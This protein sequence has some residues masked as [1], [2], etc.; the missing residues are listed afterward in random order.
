MLLK[1]LA[2]YIRLKPRV[3]SAEKGSMVLKSDGKRPP[4]RSSDRYPNSVRVSDMSTFRKSIAAAVAASSLFASVAVSTQASAAPFASGVAA[5][6][7]S[8]QGVVNSVYWRRYGHGGGWGAGAL[9]GGLI[10]GALIASAVAE[11]RA[12]RSAMNQCARDFPDFSY[13]TGT[14]IDRRGNERVCPYLR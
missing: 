1:A 8:P 6:Q 7:A 4:H 12:G 9:I 14:Y 2:F 3:R 13:R 5:A 10:G 11:N